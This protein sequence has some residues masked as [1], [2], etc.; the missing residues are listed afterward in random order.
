MRGSGSDPH[1]EYR[2]RSTKLLN[3]D[4]LW[5]RI[6]NT[7]SETLFIADQYLPYETTLNFIPLKKIRRNLFALQGFWCLRGSTHKQQ[8]RTPRNHSQASDPLPSSPGSPRQSRRWAEYGLKSPQPAE[9]SLTFRQTLV[10]LK[11]MLR[12][13][14]NF[15]LTLHIYSGE[16]K[17]LLICSFIFAGSGSGTIFLDPDP[18]KISVS[19]QFRIRADPQHC[20]KPFYICGTILIEVELSFL[21]RSIL[22]TDCRKYL[23]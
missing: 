20:L 13:V 2:S 15:F 12:F 11:E 10:R 5:I 3:T 23:L 19:M 1:S 16:I 6:H 22:Q 18:G 17:S 21:H 4:P 9:L 14:F 7:G 8:K